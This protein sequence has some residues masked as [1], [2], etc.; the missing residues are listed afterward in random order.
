MKNFLKAV[1]TATSCVVVLSTVEASA[2]DLTDVAAKQG[3]SIGYQ[4]GGDFRAKEIVISPEAL[5]TGVADAMAGSSPSLTQEQ[6]SQVL[7]ELQKRVEEKRKAMFQKIAEDNKAAEKIFLAE[8]GS[9]EGVVVLPSGLQYKI[10][11]KGEGQKP[12][13]T[14]SVTVNYR[15]TLPDGTEFDSSYKRE[16]PATFPVNRVISGWTEA[17]QLMPVGSKWILYV[18]AALGY[19]ERGSAPK[20]GPNQALVFEVELLA[21]E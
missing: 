2:I 1:V 21:V 5:A 10:V 11:K 6:M 9:K 4:L 7:M 3:Y 12:S 19:G 8:N 16:K 14:A 15:G 17:L 20:I 13:A 18:P